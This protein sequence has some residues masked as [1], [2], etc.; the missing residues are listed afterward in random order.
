[1]RAGLAKSKS[2]VRRG[3]AGAD[4]GPGGGRKISARDGGGADGSGADGGYGGAGARGGRRGG[5]VSTAEIGVQAGPP[6]VG[7]GGKGGGGGA[8]AMV[9]DER[10]ADGAPTEQGKLPG[11]AMTS[12]CEIQ[13]NKKNVKDMNRLMCRRLISAL[14]QVKVELNRADDKE[15]RNRQSFPEF[16][17]D[18]F[19][20]LYGV[21]SLAIK[22]INEFLYGVRKNRYRTKQSGEEEEEPII[23]FFWQVSHHGVPGEQRIYADDFDFYIDLLGVIGD[24]VGT[25]HTL[26]MKGGAFWNMLGSMNEIEAPVY[27][28]SNVLDKAYLQNYPA[29]CTRIKNAILPKA[30]AYA[31]LCAGPKPPKPCESYKTNLIG[32]S[33]NDKRGHLPLDDFLKTSLD[34]F[35]KQRHEDAIGLN[36]LYATWD[37]QHDSTFDSFSAMLLDAKPDMT[38]RDIIELYSQATEEMGDD[39]VHMEHIEADLRRKRVTLRV[40]PGPSRGGGSQPKHMDALDAVAAFA[41][42]TH[43]H[44]KPSGD[45]AADVAASVASKALGAFGKAKEAPADS[46]GGGGGAGNFGA[47]ARWKTAMNYA[48]AFGRIRSLLGADPSE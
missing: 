11:V 16:V 29:L 42:A 1:M 41:N 12:L 24:Y 31:K 48:T 33:T 18:Q 21:K 43:T 6:G 36:T 23:H 34:C 25:D 8:M 5:S 2:G 46:A 30:K 13:F 7:G 10:A 15:G 47:A 28:Y 44:D 19:I 20:V 32:E 4:S 45:V 17:P 37:A 40:K 27:V 14:Y 26:K 39:E 9:D 22:N 3:G 35:R 38:E